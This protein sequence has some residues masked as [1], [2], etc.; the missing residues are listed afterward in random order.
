[1]SKEKH[2]S[3][4]KGSLLEDV[5]GVI[6]DEETFTVKYSSE[7][8]DAAI[9]TNEANQIQNG[10]PHIVQVAVTGYDLGIVEDVAGGFSTPTKMEN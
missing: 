1:M 5:K 9:M 3:R 6:G 10:V 2:I 4:K 8:I 7:T